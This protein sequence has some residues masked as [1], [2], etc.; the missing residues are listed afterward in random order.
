RVPLQRERPLVLRCSLQE[1]DE[2]VD[3]LGLSKHVNELF[4][5]AS[6]R[7]SKAALVFVDATDLPDT[8]R[9][10]GRYRI[11]GNK[12]T[13]TLNLFLEKRKLARLSVTG[14]KDRLD[15]LA[16]RILAAVA[17]Q[18]ASAEGKK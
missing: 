6:A 11:A 4:R 18:L 13:V 17:K 7:G 8:Y 10:A 5:G 12:V 14:E 3:V 15:D 1:E 2:F 9:L 16:A